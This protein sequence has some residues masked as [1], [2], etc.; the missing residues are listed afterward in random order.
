MWWKVAQDFARRPPPRSS[1]FHGRSR[2]L[3][4][5]VV[6]P[7]PLAL[8]LGAI[9]DWEIA[10]SC[11]DDDDRDTKLPHR[12]LLRYGFEHDWLFLRL[13]P[14]LRG[15]PPAGSMPG[16]HTGDLLGKVSVNRPF[17][18][19]TP[20]AR[21]PITRGRPAIFAAMEDAS[22]HNLRSNPGRSY[23]ADLVVHILQLIG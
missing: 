20:A 23:R 9:M 4:F 18:R 5:A 6:A 22:S 8:F 16:Q 7:P 19:H 12:F 3:I 15:P 13:E 21:L 1:G 10:A 17:A 11:D 2:P 14:F